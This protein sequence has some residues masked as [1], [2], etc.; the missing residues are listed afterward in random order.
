MRKVFFKAVPYVKEQATLALESGVDGLVV[1]PEHKAAAAALARCAVL[2]ENDIEAVA[3]ESADDE[4]RAAEALDR[5]RTV[6]L[7]R[8]W[9]IIPVENLLAHIQSARPDRSS[10]R[11]VLALAC[12]DLAEAELA[13]GILQHGVEA[14][15]LSPEGIGEIRAVCDLAHG[16]R[17]ALALSEA[18]ITEILPAGMG[19][20]VCVDTLSV[21]RTG[22]GMLTGNSAAFTFLV[23]AE[24]E[25][26]EYVASRPFRINAGAVH[27]YALMPDDGTAYLEELQ[28]GDTV[29]IADSEGNTSTAVI[30]RVKVEQRPMLFIKAEVRNGAEVREGAEMRTGAQGRKDAVRVSGKNAVRVPAKDGGVRAGG[31]FL[32]NAETIRLVR[33]DGTP[34][35]VVSL[36]PGDTVLCRLDEAGRHFGMRISEDIKEG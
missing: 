33:P 13:F 28:S 16:G 1:P 30:G 3:L 26:N 14:V 29:L 31:V 34:V 15:V 24:T 4:A 20:R 10:A 11:G 23:N 8:G 27:A 35:S 9:E 25:R 19:H 21:L 7:E 12:G 32:Q 18:V 6:V 22:Q 2:A 17:G 5:G 36:K